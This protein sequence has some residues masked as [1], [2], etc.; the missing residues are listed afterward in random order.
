MH[1]ER[2]LRVES[3]V[4]DLDRLVVFY[5]QALGFT[6]GPERDLDP[7][8]C[9]L[10]G[11]R[12]GRARTL[13]LGGQEI[14]LTQ[15]DPPGEAYPAL[16]TAADQVFQHCALVTPDIAQAYARL[17]VFSPTTISRGGP[18]RLPQA[19]GGAEAF[20][21]RDPDGHPLELIQFRQ[22]QRAGIDHSAIVSADAERSIAFYEGL[23]LR[24][25]ARHVNV[26]P[27]QDALDGLEAVSVDVVSLAPDDPT[28][29]LELLGYRTP[30]PSPAPQGGPT[31][32]ASSRLVLQADT[33]GAPLLRQDPDG[34]RLLIL[35]R[36]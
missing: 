15:F 2:L 25:A 34:H 22:P 8:L 13:R 30:R 33:G 4:S 12:R 6:A 29:H 5:E 14:G 16:R 20:K 7:V 3:N 10:F 19:S 28:P 9:D 36:P 27:E 24:L 26:G 1:I 35:G 21:F 18:V 23:G 17:Q 11:V 31:A 32:I